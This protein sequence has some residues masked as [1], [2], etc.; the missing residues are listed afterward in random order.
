MVVKPVDLHQLPTVEAA[1]ILGGGLD[2]NGKLTKLGTD[3]LDKGAELWRSRPTTR[4]IVMGGHYWWWS[5]RAER[6]EQLT[7][8]LRAE[9]LL[10]AGV[11]ED[12]IVQ[13]DGEARD[14]ISEAFV[15]SV[16]IAELSVGGVAL[17]TSDKHMYRAFYVFTRVLGPEIPLIP[18]EVP[19]GD[20]LNDEEEAAYLSATRREIEPLG[21]PVAVPP[22]WEEWYRK[23]EEMY[24]EF[25]RIREHFAA[26]EGAAS[27]AYGSNGST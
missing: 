18:V 22:S 2:K 12:A 14:T 19:C 7:S 5:P 21:S 9:Y 17:V 3:R 11:P 27:Q 24:E 1:V 10:S 16:A 25:A 4:L 13:A 23:H 20:L 6:S 8:Q 15:A 26:Q